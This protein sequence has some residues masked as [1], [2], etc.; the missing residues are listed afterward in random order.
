MKT[1]LTK[2]KAPVARL[3][4]FALV[5]LAFGGAVIGLSVFSIVGILAIPSWVLLGSW[6]TAP[7]DHESDS[8]LDAWIKAI[9]IFVLVTVS[10]VFVPSYL[11]RLNRVARLDILLQDLVA[12]GSFTIALVASL[13][14]LYQAREAGRI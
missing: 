7:I 12:V 11:I 13:W 2:V 10:T 8:W 6:L 4:L 14:L 3:F 5:A 1:R 9:V